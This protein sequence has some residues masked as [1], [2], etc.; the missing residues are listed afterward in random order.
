MDF[1]LDFFNRAGTILNF[2]LPFSDFFPLALSDS[3]SE[4]PNYLK[5]YRSFI[6][7]FYFSQF[8]LISPKPWFH[9]FA[10]NR[11]SITTFSRMRSNRYN[12]VFS[13]FNKN[14][15]GS[16]LCPCGEKIENLN[17]VF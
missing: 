17:Y 10:I 5:H 7:T 13:F 15:V 16:P 4:C 12:L 14:L 8:L 2:Q 9:S 3:R 6:D 1:Q 11:V